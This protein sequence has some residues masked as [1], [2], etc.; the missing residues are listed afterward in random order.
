MM[1][2][3]Q[4]VEALST[5]EAEWYASVHT[6]SILI[7]LMNLAKDMGRTLDLTLAGDATAAAGI[8]QRRGAGKIR[9]LEVGTLWLQ[10]H[11]TEGRIKLVKQPGK[12]NEA[13]LG[14]KHLDAEDMHKCVTKMGF[15]F[16]EGQSTL[17]L[18]AALGA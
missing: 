6:A 4:K 12:E 8:A 15:V 16:K 5:G 14:T 11:V 13:D 2:S 17:A 18:K 7:G 9:H 10:R 1:C 3:T